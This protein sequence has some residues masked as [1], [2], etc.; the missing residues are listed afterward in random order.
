M[1]GLLEPRAATAAIW[2]V[3]QLRRVRRR[4]STMRMQTVH[5]APPPRGLPDHARPVVVAVLRVRH[6]TCLQ[7]SLVLQAWDAAHGRRRPVV[8][9]V[10]APSQGFRAHAWL[11]GDRDCDAGEGFNELLRLEP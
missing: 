10:T 4:L 9:G 8:I 3:V 6:A 2:A 5:V 11:Q 7:R 1:V